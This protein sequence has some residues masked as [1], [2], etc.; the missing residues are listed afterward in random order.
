MRR[1]TS[2]SIRARSHRRR[3]ALRSSMVLGTDATAMSA[4]PDAK[5]SRSRMRDAGVSSRPGDVTQACTTYSM[6]ALNIGDEALRRGLV[7]ISAT[8]STALPPPGGLRGWGDARHPA[9]P[10]RDA[11]PRRKNGDGD[12][13][14][15]LLGM[16]TTLW[17]AV[18][19]EVC[20][21]RTLVTRPV[22]CSVPIRRL[23]E[24]RRRHGWRP[25]R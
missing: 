18:S 21:S 12:L 9:Q 11:L 16:M 13:V 25:R 15:E 1:T 6:L 8:G 24:W 17:S 23:R 19:M 4:R 5:Y 7:T 22:P 10:Q 20:R 2:P 14:S 3:W